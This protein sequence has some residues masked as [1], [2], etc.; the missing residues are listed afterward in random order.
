MTGGSPGRWDRM[1]VAAVGDG[2]WRCRRKLPL[3]LFDAPRSIA[4]APGSHVTTRQRA[5]PRHSG[6]A[7]PDGETDDPQIRTNE[8]GGKIDRC[9]PMAW[10]NSF[11]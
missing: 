1:V 2:A 5:A 3:S 9:S 4:R 6:L 8:G 7:W 10:H 11:V